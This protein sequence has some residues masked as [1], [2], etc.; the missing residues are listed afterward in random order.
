MRYQSIIRFLEYAHIEYNVP[1]EFNLSRAKKLVNAEFAMQ[2]DGII[3]IETFS[4]TKQD[5]LTELER[6]DFIQ[7]LENHKRIWENKSLLDLLEKDKIDLTQRPSWFHLAYAPHFTAYVSEYFAPVFDRIMRAILAKNNLHNAAIW[8]DYFPFIAAENE[9]EALRSTRLYLNEVVK[10]F[11]NLNDESYKTREGELY[12]WHNSNW[13]AFFNKLPDSLLG[14]VDEIIS[15]IINFT[16]RIQK[17]NRTMCY[18]LSKEMLLVNNANFSLQQLVRS[19]HE[20]YKKNYESR[21]VKGQF[22]SVNYIYILI[23][24]IFWVARFLMSN[25]SSEK[26]NDVSYN[27]EKTVATTTAPATIQEESNLSNEDNNQFSNQRDVFL[28]AYSKKTK[29]GGLQPI[30]FKRLSTI[31][32]KP[33]R[34]YLFVE[35]NNS[36]TLSLDTMGFENLTT[37]NIIVDIIWGGN[38]YHHDLAPNSFIGFAMAKDK[39]MDFVFDFGSAY[40]NKDDGSQFQEYDQYIH[41]RKDNKAPYNQLRSELG[42][43]NE[44]PYLLHS[45]LKELPVFIKIKEN[46]D[47]VYFDIQSKAQAVNVNTSST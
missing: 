20:T 30:D 5:L 24:V 42:S 26:N 7:R 31:P 45:Q 18:E 47:Q 19:N 37:K 32:F 4:Y 40:P 28:K 16:V 2:P 6:T 1:Q 39:N 38:V 23:V 33:G 9:E 34:V 17:S 25:S 44:L 27:E 41:L 21:T 15:A 11:K 14:Y 46:M 22:N 29:T 3:E 36:G 8:L 43:P 13:S 10:F 12:M 35:S